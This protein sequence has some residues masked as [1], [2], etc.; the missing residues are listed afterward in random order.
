M[1]I[2]TK[3]EIMYAIKNGY[4]KIE[5]FD[6]QSLLDTGY[7]LHLDT[8]LPFRSIGDKPKKI[9]NWGICII[10]GYRYVIQPKEEVLTRVPVRAFIQGAD[11]YAYKIFNNGSI[12]FTFS[13][14]QTRILQP[15]SDIAT[16]LFCEGSALPL[17]YKEK[18]KKT[19]SN[20]NTH[21]IKKIDPMIVPSPS[22]NPYKKTRCK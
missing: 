18:T 8:I 7:R 16:V 6:E 15:D 9:N 1:K 21:V 11:V 3:N 14:P 20:E 22:I 19:N 17:E 12:T 4:I 13:S 5:N 2:L 10:P